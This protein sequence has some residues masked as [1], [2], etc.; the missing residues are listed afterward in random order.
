MSMQCSSFVI[1][2]PDATYYEWAEDH[3][4]EDRP[5]CSGE[6]CSPEQVLEALPPTKS[7]NLGTPCKASSSPLTTP[8]FPW[9][10]TSSLPRPYPTHFYVFKDATSPQNML[11]YTTSE[12]LGILKFKVPNLAT[13]SHI[14]AVTIPNSL[15]PG[16]LRKTAKCI[17]FQDT[18]IFL[19][20]YT[21][22]P[23]RISIH[24]GLR[25][26]MKMKTIQFRDSISSVINNTMLKYP[27]L[28]H[29]SQ[30]SPQNSKT[31]V[32]WDT[33]YHYSR[34][35]HCHLE[36]SFPQLILNHRQ[37]V[38]DIYHQDW[39]FNS[40]V[41]YSQRKVPIEYQEQ[42][43][44][45]LDDMVNKGVI[46]PV[47]WPTKWV[48]SLTDPHKLDGTLCICLNP[49]DLNKVTVQEYYKVLHSMRF[50]ID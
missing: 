28:H 36:V 29:K 48:S 49:K 39:P 43:K 32:N 3:D 12:H 31:E 17:T 46:D 6:Y 16:V 34:S 7:A 38:Q 14:D 18:L 8:G 35:G 21:F 1:H 37:H 30:V 41:Q 22:L 5:C 45:I 24:C 2:L 47:S 33:P 11:S 23:C 19:P 4:G 13:H 9:W 26:T 25:K 40:P 42:I 15:N 44:F 50:P 20:H 10:Q 27:F